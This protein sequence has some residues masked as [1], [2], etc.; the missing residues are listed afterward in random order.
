M[1]WREGD[2]VPDEPDVEA[3]AVVEPDPAAIELDPKPATPEPPL[4][5]LCKI[6]IKRTG[7][8]MTV[9]GVHAK[10]LVDNH[11]ADYIDK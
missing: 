3:E 1:R 10:I 4:P 7:K 8:V 5:A 9:G 6:R 11:R 2:T